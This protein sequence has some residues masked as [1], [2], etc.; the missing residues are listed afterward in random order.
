MDTLHR[1]YC[2]AYQSGEDANH[3]GDFLPRVFLFEEKE[4]IGKAYHRPASADGADHR[5][6]TVR[7][8]QRQHID[9]IADDQEDRDEK[10]RSER[11][12]G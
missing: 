10:N 4:S 8:P 12:N 6:Q 9:I 1:P 3:A 5:Y 7:I 2:Q 11:V